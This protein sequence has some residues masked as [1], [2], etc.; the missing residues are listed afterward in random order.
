MAALL[1][2]TLLLMFPSVL[3]GKASKV[4]VFDDSATLTLSCYPQEVP[5]I[6][7]TLS[8]TVVV[9]SESEVDQAKLEDVHLS[10]TVNRNGIT[11]KAKSLDAPFDPDF[12]SDSSYG[13]IIPVTFSVSSTLLPL[14]QDPIPVMVLASLES[15][16]L[17]NVTASIIDNR[18]EPWFIVH[19]I[20]RRDS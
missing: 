7:G 18:G 4:P 12:D 15:T 3:F 8:V 17:T 11:P 19:A 16:P 20:E 6:S 9:A 2:S 1:T 14:Q 10:I 13:K 5:L